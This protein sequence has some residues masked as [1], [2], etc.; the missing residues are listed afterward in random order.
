MWHK[1]E[2]FWEVGDWC[3]E[4]FKSENICGK[5]Y[6]LFHACMLSHVQLFVAP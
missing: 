6:I 1:I 5:T 4:F 3:F 2:S